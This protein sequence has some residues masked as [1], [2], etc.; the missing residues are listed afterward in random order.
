MT[1]Y[2]E[3]PIIHFHDDGVIIRWPTA[4]VVEFRHGATT[5]PPK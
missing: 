2:A 3:P 1:T 4:D 5:K